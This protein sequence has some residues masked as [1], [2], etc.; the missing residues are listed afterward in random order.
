MTTATVYGLG[1]ATA[2]DRKSIYCASANLRFKCIRAET[3]CLDQAE[4]LRDLGISFRSN[5]LTTRPLAYEAG[6]G[7]SLP[8][9]SIAAARASV[10]AAAKKFRRTLSHSPEKNDPNHSAIPITL[11]GATM[12]VSSVHDVTPADSTLPLSLQLHPVTEG[13]LVGG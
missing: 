4:T 9:R 8:D 11:T 3:R 13:Q 1:S 7:S 10:S 5:R 12:R 6:G 2:G